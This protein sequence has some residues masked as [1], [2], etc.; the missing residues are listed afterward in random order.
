LL[1]DNHL[2]FL[3]RELRCT[4]QSLRICSLLPRYSVPLNIPH[5]G[6]NRFRIFDCPSHFPLGI[7]H[8]TAGVAINQPHGIHLI[9]SVILMFWLLSNFSHFWFSYKLPGPVSSP[10][11]SPVKRT[12]GIPS[13]FPLGICHQM[14]GFRYTPSELW[15]AFYNSRCIA[16][17]AHSPVR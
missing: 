2:P 15:L 6:V 11:Y 9:T 3:F 13:H 17:L 4:L 16:P 10:R 14:P 5:H 1:S 7:C 12:F 8:Q